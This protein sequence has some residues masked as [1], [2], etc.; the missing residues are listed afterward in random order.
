METNAE[1]LLKTTKVDGVYNADQEKISSAQFFP[2]L[3]YQEFLKKNLKVLDLTA[4]TLA[5]G[6]N[7]PI[8]V[9]N[10][11]K[12]GNI[13]RVTLGQKVGTTISGGSQ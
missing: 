12:K 3:T 6:Q 2:H 1:A 8:V 4:V 5:M 7:L 11:R 9:F 13:K 10:L